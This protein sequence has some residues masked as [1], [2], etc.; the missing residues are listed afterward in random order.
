VPFRVISRFFDR[1]AGRYVDPGQ[2]CPLLPADVAARLVTAGCLV[3]VREGVA[4]PAAPAA[5]TAPPASPR[6][7][8]KGA[9]PPKE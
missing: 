3:A 7:P 5:P 8:R 6:A 1:A 4:A 9:T 2:D